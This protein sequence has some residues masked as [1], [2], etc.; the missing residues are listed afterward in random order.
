MILS[1]RIIQQYTDRSYCAKK[2]F[3]VSL[4]DFEELVSLDKV[5]EL[6]VIKID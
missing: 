6:Q 4:S 5:G 1:Q 3:L 2:V